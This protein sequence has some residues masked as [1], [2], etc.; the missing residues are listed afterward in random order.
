MTSQPI[1]YPR[2]VVD[3]AR[4]R[5]QRRLA[6]RL[7]A[8]TAFVAPT[9][10][11]ITDA[12]GQSASTMVDGVQFRLRG[13]ELMIVRPCAHC[14]TGRFASEPLERPADLDYA[15]AVWAPYH[16]ECE[17]QDPPDDVSW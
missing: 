10:A 13:D 3:A 16:R 2:A 9:E 8:L 4:L 15:L 5:L 17:P 12:A 1:P 14:G 7:F 6:D 11:I